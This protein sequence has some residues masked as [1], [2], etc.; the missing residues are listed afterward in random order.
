MLTQSSIIIQKNTCRCVS[1]IAHLMAMMLMTWGLV[2]TICFVFASN[3]EAQEIASGTSSRQL[4]KEVVR[5]LPY[6]QLN[7]DT[8]A[9]I[10]DILEKPSLYRRLPTTAISI[11]TEFFQ[12]LIRYPE[13]VVAIW[14]LMDI[15]HMKTDRVGP[16]SLKT[17]DGAGTTSDMELVF[18]SPDL[19]I[20]YG[21]G[22][23]EG[24]VLRKKLRG[25]CVIII[26]T[27]PHTEIN[28]GEIVGQ[29]PTDPLKT[30]CQLDVF[31]K[32]ESGAAG[33]IAKTIS[34]IVGPTADH[35][36]TES[37]KFVERLHETTV[38]NGP[39]VQQ[40]AE[41]LDIDRQVIEKFQ[42][43][44]GR[45]YERAA[46]REDNANSK[47]EF[48]G[49]G[50][51]SNLNP[52][53][54]SPVKAQPFSSATTPAST[55]YPY[56][57]QTYQYPTRGRSNVRSFNTYPAGGNFYDSGSVRRAVFSDQY[58]RDPFGR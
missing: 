19:H 17:D 47:Y 48:G 15:T 8:K 9:K 57:Q 42:A 40:M 35:N 56:Q 29:R 36:F 23:Y 38:G 28:S 49:N 33:M 58:P 50:R 31:L 13:T 10:G 26:R 7:A 4:R 27:R 44:A 12:F 52:P 18:G 1:T 20:Y 25:E 11:D 30:A 5:S 41:R 37:L 2:C 21:D 51:S 46:Q 54:S 32:L 14:E 39:G 55:A 53:Q 43:V 3:A 16:Y 6:A 45:A 22:L 24:P 34:P